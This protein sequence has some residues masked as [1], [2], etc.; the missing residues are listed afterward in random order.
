M[1]CLHPAALAEGAAG[2]A[3]AV[4]LPQRVRNQAPSQYRPQRLP[5]VV[6]VNGDSSSGNNRRSEL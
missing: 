4:V 6:E 3:E 1:H 2:A 5:P